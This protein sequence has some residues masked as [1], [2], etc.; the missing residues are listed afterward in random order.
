LCLS[1][2]QVLYR[3]YNLKHS[4]CYKGLYGIRWKNM[5]IHEMIHSSNYV[6]LEVGDATKIVVTLTKID[7]G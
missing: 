6:I 1:V 2:K 7:R 5:M 3:S 4:K